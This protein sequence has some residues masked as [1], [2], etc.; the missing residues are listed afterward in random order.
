MSDRRTRWQLYNPLVLRPLLRRGEILIVLAAIA[1]RTITGPRTID[2][3]YITFRYAQN[4]LQGNGLVYNAG[5]RGL[6]TTT[7]AY[8]ML[9]AGAGLLTGG[10]DANFPL[11]SLLINAGAAGLT[12][13][14]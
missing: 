8:A 12:C 2:D 3:A 10:A 9:L 7:P 5:E 11:L 13:S 6:G 4:L 1:A 14:L